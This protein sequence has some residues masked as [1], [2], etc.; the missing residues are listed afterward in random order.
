MLLLAFVSRITTVASSHRHR[1]LAPAYICFPARPRA[2]DTAHA[3]CR[4]QAAQQHGARGIACPHTFIWLWPL[5]AYMLL[6]LHSAH[7]ARATAHGRRT[8]PG[9]Q[10]TWRAATTRDAYGKTRAQCACASYRYTAQ[11]QRSAR[12]QTNTLRDMTRQQR[13]GLP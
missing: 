12:T 4:A 3:C 6:L 1:A 10:Q 5:V 2:N 8:L 13:N 11:A 7:A 9:Q